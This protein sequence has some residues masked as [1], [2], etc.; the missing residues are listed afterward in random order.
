MDKD[1]KKIAKLLGRNISKYRR[2]KNLTSEA[3]A[4]ENGFSKGYLSDL[5]NG[6]KI[7]SVMMLHKLSVALGVKLKDF[8]S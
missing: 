4:Y 5:E 2:K 3:L 1:A 6:K 8:F 7:P